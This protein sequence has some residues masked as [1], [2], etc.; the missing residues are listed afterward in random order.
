M[1]LTVAAEATDG[2]IH[3]A[4]VT[5]SAHKD[6][7]SVAVPLVMPGRLRRSPWQ[8]KGGGG[9]WTDA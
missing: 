8:G 5:A 3:S 1:G 4:A 2:S 9:G 7:R 6:A